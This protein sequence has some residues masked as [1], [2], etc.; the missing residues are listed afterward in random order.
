MIFSTNFFNISILQMQLENNEKLLHTVSLSIGPF[1]HFTA[2]WSNW[3]SSG[4]WAYTLD[5]SSKPR[6]L[7]P[8]LFSNNITADAKSCRYFVSIS[9][10][11]HLLHPAPNSAHAFSPSALLW[12]VLHQTALFPRLYKMVFIFYIPLGSGHGFVSVRCHVCNCK[13]IQHLVGDA[14]W[15]ARSHWLL[16]VFHRRQPG[17]ES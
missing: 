10:F 3:P 11:T 1:I 17:L 13:S 2:S 5:D 7:T 4:I 15:S 8:A 16:Q 9:P 12:F 14:S 6:D